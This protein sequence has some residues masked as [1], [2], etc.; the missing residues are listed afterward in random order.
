LAA[1]PRKRLVA[2]QGTLPPAE[3]AAVLSRL[4]A[5]RQ[6]LH[7]GPVSP[8]EAFHQAVLMNQQAGHEVGVFLSDP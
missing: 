8:Q 1:D 3:R 6:Q 4:A 2:Y 7:P 5:Q